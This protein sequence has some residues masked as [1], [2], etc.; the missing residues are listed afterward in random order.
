MKTYYIDEKTAKY[1]KEINSFSDY[2]ENSETEN[3]LSYLKDFEERVN[4]LIEQYPQNINDEALGLIEYY[5]DRYSQR[6]AFALNRKNE[7]DAMMP[8]ILISGAGNFNCRKKQKQN[9]AREN[10]WK[11]YGQLFN[12]DNYYFNKIRIIITNKIIASDDA[13]AIE[14][15]ETKIA[16]AE[17]RQELMKEVNAYYRKNKT[18]DGCNILGKQELEKV[19]QSMEIVTWYDSPF[20]TYT[21]TNNLANIKRMKER[22]ESI[23]KMKERAAINTEDKYI[24][25]DGIE[26]F[27]DATDMRIRILFDKIPNEKI[28]NKLKSN[29]FKWSPKH[30]AWQRQL[31]SNGIYATKKVL[32]EIKGEL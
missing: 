21:L 17:Q 22:V 1:A 31:T 16:D 25:V 28:R 26:V 8:S 2:K 19:K 9:N 18:L 14:K 30:N 5:K 20:P 10:F 6:L 11:E 4:G 23:K 29:G 7:I 3:Y 24:K 27:E 13:M 12:D 32:N 15:L